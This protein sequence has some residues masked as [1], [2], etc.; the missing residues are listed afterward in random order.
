M[1][2]LMTST[3]SCATKVVACLVAVL[4]CV[5]AAGAN[6][7]FNFIHTFNFSGTGASD[8]GIYRGG[9]YW[10][11][12]NSPSNLIFNT[13]GDPGDVPLAADYDG[14]GKTDYAIYRPSTRQFWWIRSS[15]AV[16]GGTTVGNPGDIPIVAD[17]DGDG[18]TDI[19][20]YRPDTSTY[21]YFRSSDGVLVS[22]PIGSPGDVPVIGD[23]DGDGEDEAAV[24][25][26]S[27][28]TF[29]FTQ[30]SN[31]AAASIQ[32]GQPGDTPLVGDFDGDGIADP[33]VYHSSSSTFTYLRSSDGS[34]VTVQ[35]GQHGD[36]PIVG[37]YDGDR[38]TD[39]AVFRPGSGT[40][41]QILYQ[42]SA[43]QQT[44]TFGF[45]NPHDTPLGAR[46]EPAEQ[47]TGL[48]Y[49]NL[50]NA[51]QLIYQAGV[52]HTDKNGRA[53]TTFDPTTS[54]FPQC[55]Y[56]TLNDDVAQSTLGATLADLKSAG[57]N[58]FKPWNGQSLASVLPDA[59]T[60]GMQLIKEMLIQP[61]NFS[62]NPS[63]DP[64]SNA[65]P[66]IAA[67]ASQIASV[68]SDAAILA[69]FAE[70]EPT[71]CVNSPTNCSERYNN[72]Q[73]FRQAIRAVDTVHPIFALDI[74][75][76]FASAGPWWNVWNSAGDVASNDN[77]PFSTGNETSLEGSA[78]DYLQLVSLNSQQKPIWITPQ[79]FQL[80]ASS[81]FTWKMPTPTQLRAEVYTAV[82]HGATGIIY[83][84]VDN[85]ATRGAQ[86]IGI[87]AN[88]RTTY[89]GQNPGDAVATS[90][91]IIAS[92]T[93]WNGA[94]SLNSELQR[95][96]SVILTPTANLSYQV[97]TQG[98]SIT[99]TPIRSILK[100]SS[101][102]VYTLL[103]VNIDN[104]PINVQFTLPARPFNLYSIGPNGARYP[105]GPYGNTF[106]DSIEG[107]GARTYE[108]K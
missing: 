66:Q 79:A 63:C 57:F 13:F 99:A 60:T 6:P 107:F 106:T 34:P 52:P 86:V 103:V 20:I 41:N 17:F 98:T 68:A 55:A 67:D 43:T 14:D 69:W 40:A 73:A 72:Y 38:K 49:T 36:I 62:S 12:Q 47:T 101:T 92:Q 88:P 54:F 61:C 104:A 5:S 108:F 24:F 81:G 100:L 37:D 44:I 58:C 56:E 30:T 80:S 70:E 91:D 1:D 48:T 83:F 78:T 53:R 65:A 26:V 75:L 90:S 102:G 59:H 46:Y 23:F 105:L 29:R 77:Y 84:A 18:K 42:A 27:S 89:P 96:Q 87:A 19:A 64:T 10:Y 9:Q 3:S 8:I 82:I 95:L 33:A 51:P 39:I 4:Y 2:T 28:A 22:V 11:F 97:A 16:V 45:G 35:W 50:P 71:A 85:F 76:P 74:S 15:D 94:V 32:I 25:N 21:W 93:L 7:R 31:G